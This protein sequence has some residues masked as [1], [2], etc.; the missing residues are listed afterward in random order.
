MKESRSIE[1]KETLTNTFLK[2]VSAYANYGT[3]QILFGITDE[4]TIKGVENPEQACLYI[5]NRINDSLDPVP[6]YV[7]AINEKTSVITLKVFE[8]LHKPYLYKAKAYRRNDSATVAVDRLSLTRL[9]LEGQNLSCEEVAAR[10]QDLQFTVL[11]EKLKAGLHLEN[12]SLD[13]LKTLELYKEGKGFTVAGELFADQNSFSGI[14][15]V[16]FGDSISILLDRETYAGESILKQYDDAI[17]LYRR[18]YQY[19]QISGSVREK[20]VTI[21]E[22]AFREAIANALVHRTWDVDTNINVAMFPDKIEITS[23]GGLPQGVSE[24]EY[25]RGGISVLRNRVI[26]N[27]FF[28]LHLIERFGTGIR[29]IKEAYRN[30]EAKPVFSVFENSLKITLPVMREQ[31]G[32]TADENKIYKAVKKRSVPSSVIIEETGFGKSK[33]ISV[34]RKL[35]AEGYVTSTGNG[36]GT[37]YSAV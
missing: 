30:S 8:G 19:E 23:P 16:R 31:N 10:R 5:E 6:E 9:I 35:V 21:P 1:F 24:D 28:R 13:T 15:M 2:T 18:Y 14:D 17:C 32:L 12:V 34:L 29:R 7:L 33:V 25:I 27:I 11:E 26:G 20:V 37:R 4:G 3:G 22:E 36:R